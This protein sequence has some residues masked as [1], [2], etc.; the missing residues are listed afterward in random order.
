MKIPNNTKFPNYGIY[1]KT[2]YGN[3]KWSDFFYNVPLLY[4]TCVPFHL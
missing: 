3:E 2:I 4:K 1:V